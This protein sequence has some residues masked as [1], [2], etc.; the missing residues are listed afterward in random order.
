M[1]GFTPLNPNKTF[2]NEQ[3]IALL[4]ETPR[5][6][7]LGSANRYHHTAGYVAPRSF[8]STTPS[9]IRPEPV[10]NSMNARLATD[11]T[12]KQRKIQDALRD[13]QS[14]DTIG[15]D[16]DTG[17]RGEIPVTSDI[18]PP[19]SLHGR[20]DKVDDADQL[21]ITTERFKSQMLGTLS[22]QQEDHHIQLDLA[23]YTNASMKEGATLSSVI[24][25][26]LTQSAFDIATAKIIAAVVMADEAIKVPPESAD[27]A[28][29]D[30]GKDMI[31]TP[32]DKGKGGGSQEEGAKTEAD[33]SEADGDDPPKDPPA[34]PSLGGKPISFGGAPRAPGKPPPG[35]GA[36]V[37]DGTHIAT[38]NT[39]NLESLLTEALTNPNSNP[40][41]YLPAS[42]QEHIF[43]IHQEVAVTYSAEEINHELWATSALPTLQEY[44]LLS[45]TSGLKEMDKA[46][47]EC[48]TVSERVDL[49]ANF[50]KLRGCRILK[51]LGVAEAIVCVGVEVNSVLSCMLDP[52][53]SDAASDAHYAAQNQS[54][55]SGGPITI[56]LGVA[57]NGFNYFVKMAS[58]ITGT[59]TRDGIKALIDDM[60]DIEIKDNESCR[61]FVQRLSNMHHKIIA[62]ENMVQARDRIY[63]LGLL[64]THCPHEI[65]FD[66]LRYHTDGASEANGWIHQ[67]QQDCNYIDHGCADADTSTKIQLMF[68][69][70]DE[71]ALRLD[72]MAISDRA[73][74]KRGASRK[75]Q[76]EPSGGSQ[77]GYANAARGRGQDSAFVFRGNYCAYCGSHEHLISNCTLKVWDKHKRQNGAHATEEYIKHQTDLGRGD[78][79]TDK[80][81][82][83]APMPS[84]L[85]PSYDNREDLA[86]I[87]ATGKPTSDSNGAAETRGAQ[88]RGGRGNESTQSNGKSDNHALNADT[89]KFMTKEDFAKFERAMLGKVKG[90]P[91]R[92]HGGRTRKHKA[93]YN[94]SSETDESTE[95]ESDEESES[96]EEEF[97]DS[98]KGKH[99][100][101]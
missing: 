12:A 16:D 90:K 17:E 80:G 93:R 43:N 46:W 63:S 11:F 28:V 49:M 5:V 36:S 15:A 29:A 52:N 97:E 85:K 60:V 92:H 25:A 51:E 96:E 54:L 84:S 55:M 50:R 71:C 78:M 35:E 56:G 22:T 8:S 48:D 64:T 82:R 27:P 53:M 68:L 4:S 32:T 81:H 66:A 14:S 91:K 6:Q 62:A 34:A 74:R 99:K 89:D 30:L 83:T 3:L 42:V 33:A 65:A 38:L 94:W 31:A 44:V 67:C 79:I 69:A 39:G 26:Q 10:R 73:I 45:M 98:K 47:S 18:V 101:K 23:V 13:H 76:R 24:T 77:R 7:P 72:R 59:S 9:R 86:S 20:K 100:K 19:K 70:L 75:K 58:A 2:T 61:L 41:S 87:Q 1:A 88:T 40:S 95:S 21:R 37:T 57:P